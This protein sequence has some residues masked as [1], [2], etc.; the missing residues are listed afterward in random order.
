MDLVESFRDRF[1][2]VKTATDQPLQWPRTYVYIDGTLFA[3]DD[4]PD[5][6]KNAVCQLAVEAVSI[7]LQPNLGG[8]TVTKQKVDVVEVEYA[9]RGAASDYTVFSKANAFLSPLLSSTGPL[10]PIRI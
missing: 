6:L 2:G 1:R 9:A 7:D 5:E 4:I 10:T 3:S 8:R